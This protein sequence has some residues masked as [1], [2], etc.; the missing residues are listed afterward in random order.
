[1]KKTIGL[2]DVSTILHNIRLSTQNSNFVEL[3]S[4]ISQLKHDLVLDEVI[5]VQ[6][7]GK[8]SYRNEIYPDYKGHRGKRE[9]SDKELEKLKEMKVWN[10]NLHLFNQVYPSIKIQ[11]V[12]ADDIIGML[13]SKFKD[14]FEIICISLDKDFQTV[15]PLNS[16]YNWKK[17]QYFTYEDRYELSQGK[18]IML[19]TLIGDKADNIHSFCGLKTA[20]VLLDNFKNFPEMIEFKGEVGDLGGVTPHN[21]RYVEKALEEIKTEEGYAKLKLNHSLISIFKDTSKLTESQLIEFEKACE[22]ILAL[23]YKDKSDKLI[24]SK[25]LEEFLW[26]QNCLEVIEIL[27]DN[28]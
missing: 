8:S 19:Q 5:L 25:E 14:T 7:W 4:Y 9:L 1:M 6:D 26:E 11:N 20:L 10:D 2:V 24:V 18:F 21:K 28:L 23:E 17:K 3:F 27:E 16:L 13:F 22:R 15:I 12:E